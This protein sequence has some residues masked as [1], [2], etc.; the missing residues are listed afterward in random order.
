MLAIWQNVRFVTALTVLVPLAF[1][2]LTLL[3]IGLA[4]LVLPQSR[5]PSAFRAMGILRQVVEVL[6]SGRQTARRS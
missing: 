4:V 2:C 3:V 6:V 1:V 5:H